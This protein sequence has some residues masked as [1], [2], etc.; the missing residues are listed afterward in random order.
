MKILLAECNISNEKKIIAGSV[1]F[2]FSDTVFYSFNGRNKTGLTYHANDLIQWEA[3]RN[4][5]ERGFTYYDMGEVSNCNTSLAQFKSKW[6]CDSK[7]IYHYYY[8]KDYDYN[9]NQLDISPGNVFVKSVWRKLP[10]DLTR[11]FGELAYKYL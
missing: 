10:L 6:G 1:F 5:C 3:I 4:S 7:Q 8:S 2:S 9:S 11:K